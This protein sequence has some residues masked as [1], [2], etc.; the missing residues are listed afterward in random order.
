MLKISCSNLFRY[1]ICPAALNHEQEYVEKERTK[2]AE[3][4]IAKH[5]EMQDA[6]EGT[7]LERS[8]AAEELRQEF[9][10]I[11][12]YFDFDECV[13][14]EKLEYLILNEG[15][16]SAKLIGKPDLIYV[17]VDTNTFYIIDYKFGYINVE[18]KRNIQLLSYVYLCRKILGLFQKDMVKETMTMKVGIFQDSRLKLHEVTEEEMYEFEHVDLPVMIYQSQQNDY[19]PSP[20]ACKWCSYREECPA[21]NQQ[22][23]TTVKK[24]TETD[25]QQLSEPDMFEF[26]KYML[27]N[28]K[29]IEYVLDDSE[30]FFKRNLQKGAFY[31]WCTLKSNGAVQ[32]WSDDL[33]E[34]EIAS[35]LAE[36]SNKDKSNFYQKKLLS[37]S[38]IKKLVDV[39]ADLIITKDKA[40][41]LK[42]KEEHEL[43]TA[44]DELF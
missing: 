31:D 19:Q 12:C 29:L 21:L 33:N 16:I 43:K 10:K 5:K 8:V 38:Q 17:D 39:P 18:P 36:I 28:K 9:L 11:E 32:S 23:N 22:V 40:K 6:I 41:S 3:E 42:I 25:L 30:T 26:R 37:V 35:K 14:E 24:I 15:K 27:R 2:Y 7:A 44:T 20:T 4:G 1:F 13:C 34:D